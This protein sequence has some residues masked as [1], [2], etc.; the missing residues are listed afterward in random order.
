MTLGGSKIRSVESWEQ[1]Y[2][3]KKNKLTLFSV[4]ETK[5]I[6]IVFWEKNYSIKEV[7][8]NYTTL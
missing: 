2:L 3:P 1:V 4:I 6:D 8:R 7:N 5:H